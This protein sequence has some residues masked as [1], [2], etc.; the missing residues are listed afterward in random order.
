M[1]LPFTSL[2]SDSGYTVD[3]NPTPPPSELPI[4]Q[5]QV[6]TP[7]FFDTVDM[8]IARG[9]DFSADD[10]YGRPQVAIINER[11]ARDAFSGADPLGR[12]IHTG[13]TLESSKGMQIVAV[14]ADAR[15]VSPDLPARPEIYLPYLQHPGPGSR[16]ELLAHTSIAPETLAASIREAARALNPEVPVRFST[17]NDAFSKALAY[18]RFRAVL[19]AGFAVLAVALALVGIYGVLSYLVAERTPEIGVRMALGALRRDIFS[20]VINAS[21]RLVAGGLLAGLLGTLAVVRVLQTVLYGVSPRDPLT[22]AAV[23]CLFV[24]TAF[25]ASSIPALR[26]SRVDPLVALRQD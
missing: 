7:G 23:A 5:I 19:V 9:R 14:V 25:L 15:E 11:L 10:E 24:V 2:W 12:I 1:T 4:A 22:I 16:L 20:H 6:V 3:G 26:A 21:M 17:M 18:P 13:M 8:R